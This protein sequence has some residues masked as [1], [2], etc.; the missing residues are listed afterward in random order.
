MAKA[1]EKMIGPFYGVGEIGDLGE[2]IEYYFEYVI[3]Q[4]HVR[5]PRR[6]QK[7]VWIYKFKLRGEAKPSDLNVGYARW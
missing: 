3:S 5:H 7:C 6:F 2:G 4:L 1:T